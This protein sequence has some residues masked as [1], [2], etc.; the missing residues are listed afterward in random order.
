MA[1]FS[2][3]SP[4]WGTSRGVNRYDLKCKSRWSRPFVLEYNVTNFTSKFWGGTRTRLTFN[5][6]MTFSTGRRPVGR[7]DWKRCFNVGNNTKHE[8]LRFLN[9][10]IIKLL[11]SWKTLGTPNIIQAAFQYDVSIFDYYCVTLLGLR[12]NIC[13][14]F[15]SKSVIRLEEAGSYK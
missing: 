11:I 2:V 5:I 4:N 15:S 6:V 12:E 13:L 8:T 9:L 10:L 3:I 14:V 7:N 1:H